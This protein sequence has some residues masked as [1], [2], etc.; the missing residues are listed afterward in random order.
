MRTVTKPPYRQLKRSKFMYTNSRSLSNKYSEFDQIINAERIHIAELPKHGSSPD[1]NW[2]YIATMV[3]S[4][5]GMIAELAVL[6][7]I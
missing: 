3:T 1:K 7:S 2:S 6:P 5:P 4:A